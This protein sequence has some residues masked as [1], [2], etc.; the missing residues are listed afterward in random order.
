MKKRLILLLTLCLLM[1]LTAMAASSDGLLLTPGEGELTYRFDAP[2]TPF[3]LMEYKTP[4]E[5]GKAVLHQ[6]DGQGHYEGVL[7]LAYSERGGKVT[8]KISTLEDKQLMKGTAE[9]PAAAESLPEGA[10]SRPKVSQLEL[11]GSAEGFHY[12][13]DAPGAERLLLIFDS[14]TQSGRTYIAPVDGEG[15]FEG[16]IALPWAYALG[17]VKVQVVTANG[18]TQ[19]AKGSCRKAYVAPTPGEQA[20]EGRLKG[21]TVCIDPGHQAKGS[22]KNVKE[23]LGPGLSKSAVM[24]GGMAEGCKT[25]RLEHIVVLE[26][27]EKLR[28]ELLR[29]G[30]TVVM[31]RS[32]PDEF[33]SNMN[34]AETANAAQ[35]DI[36]LRLHCDLS[37]K[38]SK[39]GISIH[40]PVHSDYA[41]AVADADTYKAMGTLLLDA[42][43]DAVGYEKKP[44]TGHVTL[45]D[46][47]VGN[48]WAKMPCFLVEMGYMS[49]PA[50]D[51][52]L[53]S[54][55]YQQLLAEGMA[56]GVYD[57]MAMRGVAREEA[58][59]P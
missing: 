9:L 19:L 34:R 15:H 2:E 54:P 42:M 7:P 5:S 53:S 8:V 59:N 32:A 57:I 30:A 35:A 47:F 24:Q 46:K 37:G 41:R 17:N 39:R 11:E 44:A 10:S 48:N 33:I 22:G 45:T 40:S 50:E 21:V 1:P 16:D 58:A 36:L 51:R 56:Q 52:L 4:T 49:N 55:D 27:A 28:A 13:F 12:S 38:A 18:K 3:V 23:P 26:I 20:A 29:Q 31:T 43:R 14:L 6:S 25:Y